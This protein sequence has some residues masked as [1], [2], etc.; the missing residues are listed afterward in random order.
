MQFFSQLDPTS[1]TFLVAIFA[2]IF[3]SFAS[4]LSRRLATNEPIIFARSKCPSC[5][6]ALRVFNLIP[7][8]SWLLQRGKCS[9]CHA[10]ISLRYPLIEL[11]FLL[12]FLAIFFADGR[13][14]NAQ[15]LLHFAI[16]SVMLVMCI[17]DLEHYFIPKKLQ[18]A[19]AIFTT[20][21]LLLKGGAPLVLHNIPSAFLYCGFGLGLLALFRFAAKV[22]A[23]GIDDIEFFFVAGLLLGTN[24]FLNFMFLSGF[25]G[26][27][28]GSF[29]QKIMS[30]KTFPFAPSICLAAMICLLF[31]GK[32]KLVDVMGSLLFLQTF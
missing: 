24:N 5:N 25:F 17:T 30:E 4:L 3:G 19:L 28:F 23:I 12:S 7:I 22:E 14:I 9:N 11:V 10:K 1:Q 29:W 18:Y 6:K 20:I 32:F 13:Q 26:L 27:V 8:F 16:A 2:L 15:T 21:L 31:D